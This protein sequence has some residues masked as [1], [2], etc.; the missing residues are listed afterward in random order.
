MIVYN[1][2][3]GSPTF[4]VHFF[5]LFDSLLKDESEPAFL[6]VPPAHT[7]ARHQHEVAC[8]WGECG[9]LSYFPPTCNIHELRSNVYLLQQ[10]YWTYWIKRANPCF[11]F[12]MRHRQ[13]L[14][15]RPSMKSKG[16]GP[17]PFKCL[18]RFTTSKTCNLAFGGI[19]NLRSPVFGTEWRRHCLK[20]RHTR[21]HGLSL[22]L[23]SD[24]LST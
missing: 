13:N 20:N 9:C 6:K 10:K 12:Y 11:C 21:H 8:L 22:Q 16:S 3:P 5:A 7:S 24:P 15:E 14:F 23:Y 4:D 1:T 2:R 18:A 19:P 17:Y